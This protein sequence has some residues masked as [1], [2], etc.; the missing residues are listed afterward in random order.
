MYTY[1]TADDYGYYTVTDDTGYVYK[2]YSKI[3][4][5]EYAKPIRKHPEWHFNQDIYS[6]L[7][8]TQEPE[9]DLLEMYKDR[10][11]QL[12]SAYDYLILLYSSGWDSSAMAQSFFDAGVMPDELFSFYNSGDAESDLHVETSVYTFPKLDSINKLYPQVKTRRVNTKEFF[13]HGYKQYFNPTTSLDYL[14][15]YNTYLAPNKIFQDHMVD[16]V[17]E[18]KQMIAQGK[19]VGIVYGIDKP[20]VRYSNGRWIAYFQDTAQS[21]IGAFYQ[22]HGGYGEHKEYFFWSQNAP[23]IAIKQ[24]HVVKNTYAKSKTVLNHPD[25]KGFGYKI[26]RHDVVD[27][28]YPHVRDQ[29]FYTIK[30]AVHSMGNRDWRF[31]NEE[32]DLQRRYWMIANHME[33]TLDPKWKIK[34]SFMKNGLTGQINDYML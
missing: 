33:R 20:L 14:Y 13:D 22:R 17:P 16:H 6:K 31:L 27:Y 10:A 15:G 11:R 4:A 25:S 26:S 32:G 34:G 29:H 5:I 7:D 23:F 3:D 28:I 1:P 21:E 30:P 8:W 19:R 18:W 9:Q 12:R 2:T 24:A